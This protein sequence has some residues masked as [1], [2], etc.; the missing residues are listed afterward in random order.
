MWGCLAKVMVPIPKRIKIGPKT[1]NCIF[2]SYAISSSAYRFL[3]HN[4]IFLIYMSIQLL[5]QEM[6]HSLKIYFLVKCM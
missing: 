3:V 1:I 5:S 2:I 4:P 6:Y